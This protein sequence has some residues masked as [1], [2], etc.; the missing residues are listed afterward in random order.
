M[1]R[2]DL[3]QPMGRAR[4][5]YME[6][7]VEVAAWLGGSSEDGG[8]P[9]TQ[10]GY[11]SEP[12]ERSASPRPSSKN[13]SAWRNNTTRMYGHGGLEALTEVTRMG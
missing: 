9:S 6:G 13:G 2:K 10:G 11:S 8:S 4:V 12:S 5:L 7:L 3:A 1:I